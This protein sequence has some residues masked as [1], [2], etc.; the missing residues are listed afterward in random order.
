MAKF[1]VKLC[2]SDLKPALGEILGVMRDLSA[3][4]WIET[5]EAKKKNLSSALE[6]L[7]ASLNKIKL[8]V[9]ITKDY[10]PDPGELSGINSIGKPYV[11]T[12]AFH[13]PDMLAKM[14]TEYLQHSQE[15]QQYTRD[16]DIELTAQIDI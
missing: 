6:R 3:M 16:Q 9:P 5:D 12:F 14:Y 8:V 10:A 15:F 11:P 4:E 13:D 2:F 7:G 1:E